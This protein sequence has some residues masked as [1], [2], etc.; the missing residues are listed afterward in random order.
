MAQQINLY[1]PELLKKRDWLALGNVVAVSL[2]L[3]LLVG[4]AGYLARQDLPA[5]TAQAATGDA[6]LK[7]LRDQV[8]ALGQSVATRK[9]DATLE[10]ELET[11]RLLAAARGEV[12]DVLK[13]RVGPDAVSYAEYLRGFARQTL[14][15]LWLTGFA[16][17]AA[18][19]GMEISGRTVDPALLPQYI[20]RLNR[21][22]VFQGRAFAALNLSAGQAEPKTGAPAPAAGSVPP[23]KK[24]P[25]HE[26]KL[27]PLKPL[28]V[29]TAGQGT[30]PTQAHNAGRPG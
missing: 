28:A 18:S 7:A 14:A 15:G 26:F 24:A 29:D 9:P 4:G 17:D 3:A 13:Q 10:K 25:F 19:G 5:L 11:T 23:P 6:Q 8:T 30:P 22:P 21:E 1:S 27:I 20:Q 12:L 16:Y 2:V